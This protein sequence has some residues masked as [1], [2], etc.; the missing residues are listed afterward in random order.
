M[1]L[2]QKRYMEKYLCL[3]AHREPYIPYD[4]MIERMVELNSSASNVHGVVDDN[5]NL[6]RNMI[7]N[8]MGM[9]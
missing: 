3:H 8:V 2:L 7:I 1:Y 6:Y 5:S 4:I 9:N